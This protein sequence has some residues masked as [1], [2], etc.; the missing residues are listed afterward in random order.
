MVLR[1]ILVHCVA[2]EYCGNKKGNDFVTMGKKFEYKNTKISSDVCYD[3]SLWWHL[4]N[5]D[6]A[7][8]Q[9]KIVKIPK[10]NLACCFWF[11]PHILTKVQM[12][13]TLLF[14]SVYSYVQVWS[15]VYYLLWII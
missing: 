2:L 9:M 14:T 4:P 3:L 13:C 11:S 8:K 15:L 5:L 6:I 12:C 10:N 7:F 1:Q